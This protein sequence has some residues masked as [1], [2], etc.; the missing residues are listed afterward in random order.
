[1]HSRQRCYDE[2]SRQWL[3]AKAGRDSTGQAAVTDQKT[4][5]ILLQL[6]CLC[7]LTVLGL[8]ATMERPWIHDM[9][10]PAKRA[11]LLLLTEMEMSE[12]IVFY[13][14]SS[15]VAQS[16]MG[17]EHQGIPAD[18]ILEIVRLE[19][20]TVVELY[21]VRRVVFLLCRISNTAW[22]PAQ[23]TAVYRCAPL[24]ESSE[25]FENER[26][27]PPGQFLDRKSSLLRYTSATAFYQY[28]R[29]ELCKY[30]GIGLKGGC[31]R[32]FCLASTSGGPCTHTHTNMM[33]AAF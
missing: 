30:S 21:P 8:D 19:S 28:Y 14:P 4:G 25:V 3:C 20:T 13:Q 27:H 24:L 29:R 18:E 6:H 9:M 2:P 1:M 23:H 22:R 11:L 33:V 7:C 5:I 32:P 15:N 31:W 12:K 17:L 16:L 10:D 26:S